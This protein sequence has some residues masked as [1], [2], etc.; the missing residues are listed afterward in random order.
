MWRSF[1]PAILI[2]L[3]KS[4]SHGEI[5]EFPAASTNKLEIASGSSIQ[6]NL[7]SGK[8]NAADYVKL[9]LKVGN[10]SY[11][12]SYIGLNGLYINGPASIEADPVVMVSYSNNPY[13]KDRFGIIFKDLNGTG[14]YS[15]LIQTNAWI[16][17]PVGATNYSPEA[18]EYFNWLNAGN[19]P[20]PADA[21]TGTNISSSGILI[22]YEGYSNQPYKTIIVTSNS[23]QTLV[24]P[25]GKKLISR[26]GLGFTTTTP[27]LANPTT[28]MSGGLFCT[29]RDGYPIDPSFGIQGPETLTL[30][31]APPIVIYA[32]PIVILGAGGSATTTTGSASTTSYQ[33]T[34][35]TFGVFAYYFTDESAE[36]VSESSVS[37]VA[38]KTTST[39]G[40]YGIATK[41]E[42][43]TALA[44]SRTDGIN[45][46]LSNPNLWTLYTA[47]Q[48]QNMAMGDL[49]LNKNTNG[50]FTLNYDIE[51]STDLL[52]WTPYQ[53]LP[54]P[55]NGLPTN[56]AF[57]RIKLKNSQ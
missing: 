50:N 42:L 5:V 39:T 53:A 33:D 6:I 28:S 4:I 38:N 37:A 17:Y 36:P 19:T 52:T 31:Y 55:L 26:R 14:E 30:T 16:E 8:G 9:K 57:V 51:Q 21:F 46:V 12:C 43:N 40:N 2:L 3:L 7:A 13:K 41:A 10:S 27:I 15:Y 20:L 45:N 34:R 1:S 48:I 44:Q 54:L 47:N 22:Q 25:A 24:I 56:K 49:V 35:S 11:D 32:P 23:T 18:I 29:V